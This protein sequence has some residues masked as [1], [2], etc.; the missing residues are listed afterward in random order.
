MR[1]LTTA[2]AFFAALTAVAAQ[3]TNTAAPTGTP[4]DGTDGL[5]GNAITSPGP[6]DTIT[7][8]EDFT[9]TWTNVRGGSVTLVLVTGDSDDLQPVATIVAN[10][11]NDG[12]YTWS[13][14]ED[15]P[16][17]DEYAIRISYDSNPNNYNY[18][19]RFN[20]DSDVTGTPTISTASSTE[21]PTSTTE[22]ESSTTDESSTTESESSTTSGASTTSTLR[23]TTTRRPT[24]TETDEEDKP[25]ETDGA[26]PSAA[27]STLS[28]PLAVIM[29]VLAA[30]LF[31]H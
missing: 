10:V 19:D 1:F 22:T 25:E 31:I 30:A 21:P 6:T 17:S 4:N 8:G 9:I 29:A 16:A 28:S 26:P 13:V 14:P 24:A 23:T 2:V 20:F 3:S 18:S 5:G 11:D 27:A 15:L 12:S 7:A